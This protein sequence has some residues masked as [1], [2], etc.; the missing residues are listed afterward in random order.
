MKLHRRS[1]TKEMAG[2]L[3]KCAIRYTAT[4]KPLLQK[5]AS[6][7]LQG[8]EI[9]HE[10]V[11]NPHPCSNKN[12][13]PWYTVLVLLARTTRCLYSSIFCGGIY[14]AKPVTQEQNHNAHDTEC[15]EQVNNNSN[16]KKH[17]THTQ[18]TFFI[19]KT[20]PERQTTNTYSYSTLT[21]ARTAATSPLQVSGRRRSLGERAK[22][23]CGSPPRAGEAYAPSGNTKKQTNKQKTAAAAAGQ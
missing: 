18:N 19:F 16:N 13:I 2:N 3:E 22:A 12:G 10:R 15:R 23:L 8:R 1:K 5:C 9:Y 7:G 17:T 6:T 21:P 20:M 11:H 14:D 4:G